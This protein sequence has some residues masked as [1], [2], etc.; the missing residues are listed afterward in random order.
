MSAVV[1]FANLSAS[2]KCRFVYIICGNKEVAA[3]AQSLQQ[4]SDRCEGACPTVIES[5]HPGIDRR[6]GLLRQKVSDE[7]RAFGDGLLNRLHV[8]LELIGL[9]FVERGVCAGKAARLMD[10]V[11]DDVVVH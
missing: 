2:H 5:K 7:D 4:V 9:Q 11:L 6:G 1:Q 8:A 10:R 3:P